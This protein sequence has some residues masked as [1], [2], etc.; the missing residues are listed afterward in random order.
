MIVYGRFMFYKKVA[1]KKYDFQNEMKKQGEKFDTKKE[2]EKMA[3]RLA[4]H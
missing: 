2:I 4:E 1:A 3:R